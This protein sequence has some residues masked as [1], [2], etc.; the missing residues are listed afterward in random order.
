MSVGRRLRKVLQGNNP[1]LL[2][3][4]PR[5]VAGL[6][7]KAFT[8]LSER[9]T[10]DRAKTLYSLL[11]TYSALQYVDA[12]LPL[13]TQAFERIACKLWR[14]GWRLRRPIASLSK[15]RLPSSASLRGE[16]IENCC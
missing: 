9:D 10:N 3:R 2:R 4:D 11:T 6:V 8:A 12:L 13:I 15:P 14:V 7:L 1:T 16:K 5:E